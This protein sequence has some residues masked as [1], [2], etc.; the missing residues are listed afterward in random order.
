MTQN[1]F[2][3]VRKQFGALHTGLRA[4]LAT[5]GSWSQPLALLI[6]TIAFIPVLV[7][8]FKDTNYWSSIHNNSY[9]SPEL[10]WDLYAYLIV[11]IIEDP[12]PPLPFID[13]KRFSVRVGQLSYTP[14]V[15]EEGKIYCLRGLYLTDGF[16][17]YDEESYYL[18][19]ELGSVTSLI[20]FEGKCENLPITVM[21]GYG[22]EPLD[23]EVLE[24]LGIEPGPYLTYDFGG[25]EERPVP[26]I[27]ARGTGYTEFQVLDDSMYP[28]D[29][30]TLETSIFAVVEAS[31]GTT[32]RLAPEVN[33]SFV[34]HVLW[35]HDIELNYSTVESSNSFEQTLITGEF[36]RPLTVRLFTYS[37]LGTILLFIVGLLFAK[38][39]S[40]V[41]E[42][43]L[44]ILL[45]LWSIK[46][47]LIPERVPETQTVVHHA[48]PYL[49]LL[50]SLAVITRLI[51]MP[52]FEKVE[53]SQRSSSE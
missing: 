23:P 21:L 50:F 32:K 24:E 43:S 5:T 44:G 12:N 4:K 37:V 28:A 36:H 2:K 14:Y 51:L 6:F 48:I 40:A 22:A 8:F 9:D 41:M 47:F 29:R 26:E 31:D 13:S 15:D 30:G 52:I 19:N 53:Q 1:F 38:D 11:R 25:I 16:S 7:G 49:Y 46:S 17:G 42:I 18:D 35:L 39:R 45:G 34:S 33:L 10:P 3:N 20:S 27:K